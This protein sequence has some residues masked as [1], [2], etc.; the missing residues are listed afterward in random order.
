MPAVSSPARPALILARAVAARACRS[1]F[2]EGLTA[3]E[4]AAHDARSDAALLARVS[5]AVE[6]LVRDTWAGDPAVA[7]GAARATW[8]LLPD[9]GLIG[10][11]W[12][13][14]P[15]RRFA[16]AGTPFGRAERAPDGD[17]L[18]PVKMAS[19]LASPPSGSGEATPVF[20]TGSPVLTMRAEGAIARDELVVLTGEGTVAAASSLLPHPATVGACIALAADAAN[21]LVA[22][23]L[24]RQACGD[25]KRV[26]W[27]MVTAAEHARVAQAMGEYGGP[28]PAWFY[29]WCDDL[30]ATGY[31]V[32]GMTGDVITLVCPLPPG[33]FPT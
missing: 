15:R 11:G 12:V 16:R 14:D 10:P 25:H 28:P 2:V 33:G 27:R 32:D 6:A 30:R 22:E 29:A 8:E 26:V 9:F 1:A 4:Q 17:A 5:A 24:A 31:A 19:G 18:V 21:V 3:A 13:D 7:L 23:E 20:V